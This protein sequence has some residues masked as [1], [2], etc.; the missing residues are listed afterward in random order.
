MKLSDYQGEDALDLL[1]DILEPM[2]DIAADEKLKAVINKS[3]N[4][5]EVVYFLL[6]NHKKEILAI[7]ARIEGVAVEDYKCTVFTLPK[8]ILEFINDES[9]AELFCSQGQ[10]KELLNSGSATENTEGTEQE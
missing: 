10:M 2:T 4:K 5:L 3:R 8:A 6:K 9:A 7:L 1:A